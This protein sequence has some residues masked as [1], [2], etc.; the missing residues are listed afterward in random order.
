MRAGAIWI[1]TCPGCTWVRWMRVR[2]MRRASSGERPDQSFE[3]AAERSKS[4]FCSAAWANG[5]IASN[6][7][8]R[9]EKNDLSLCKTTRSI[10]PAG[11]RKPPGEALLFLVM[12]AVLRKKWIP[13]KLNTL[14]RS[15][16]ET[17]A[18]HDPLP[19]TLPRHYFRLYMANY[20]F[21]IHRS[22]EQ[23]DRDRTSFGYECQNMFF[24]L[25]LIAVLAFK[26]GKLSC[27]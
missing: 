13:P 18:W 1:S 21:A 14:R 12:R 20:Q 26:H 6:T 4:L 15:L 8:D 16:D 22:N 7:S 25:Q 23:F 10:S 24:G 27:R 19:W 17:R 3:S 11:M 2:Q 5:S 9:F